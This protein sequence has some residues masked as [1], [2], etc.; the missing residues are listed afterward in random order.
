MPSND[1]LV[2]TPAVKQTVLSDREPL[3]V[4]TF[5]MERIPDRFRLPTGRV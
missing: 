5:P 1:L 2:M 3:C 4:L